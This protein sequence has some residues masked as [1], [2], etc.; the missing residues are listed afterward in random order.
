MGPDAANP[1]RPDAINSERLVV[2]TNEYAVGGNAGHPHA[3][4][5]QEQAFYILE[6]KME[7]TVGDETYTA[8]P[9]DCVYL[10]RN[11][12]HGHKNVGDVPPKFI[13]LSAMLDD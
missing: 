13:F 8:V 11:V 7:V 1:E 10:P 6:G 9:G 2:H 3:H 12:M 4:S 5:N